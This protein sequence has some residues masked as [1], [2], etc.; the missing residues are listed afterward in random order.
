[1]CIRDSPRRAREPVGALSAA[2]VVQ[3]DAE[4][5]ARHGGEPALDDLPR[6]EQ[7]GERHDRDCLL[8]TSHL[9]ERGQTRA[10]DF[11]IAAE[12]VHHKPPQ[13][14]AVLGR[15]ERDLSLIHI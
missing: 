8:Y 12:L 13:K 9:L 11:H 10:Q 6:R 15:K 3:T 5:G 7:V 2:R 4:V 1:M 14:R